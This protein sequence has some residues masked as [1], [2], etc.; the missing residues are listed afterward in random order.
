MQKIQYDRQKLYYKW[1]ILLCILALLGYTLYFFYSRY[2][3]DSDLFRDNVSLYIRLVLVLYFIILLSFIERLPK[4]IFN[5]LGFLIVVPIG[6][7]VSIISFL[8]VGYE[9]ISV[10]GFIF[11]ILSSAVVFDFSTLSF[12]VALFFILLFHFILLSFYPVNQPE[13]L[14]NHIFLLSLAGSIG[15]ATNYMINII[16]NNESKVLQERELLLKEVHHRVKNNL[17]IISS[18]LN[19]QSHS[20]TDEPVKAVIK[21]SQGRVKSIAMIHQLLYQS[22]MYS[23]IDFSKYLEQLMIS[24]RTTY[25]KSG[26]K[27]EY[28]IKAEKIRLDIDTAIK[29]GIITNELVTNSYKY[30]FGKN[31]EGMIHIGL[32]KNENHE[33]VYSIWDNGKGLPKNFNLD[34]TET[35]GLKL[36]KLLSQELKAKLN[37]TIKNGTRFQFVFSIEN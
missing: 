21:E 12:A 25:H 8:T 6:W 11:I 30:A 27:I 36:V 9:G 24:I 1:A 31:Q 15:L 35:L 3:N 23:S 20:V 33:I 22:G 7:T 5:L 28:A 18:L 37:Y 34:Q 17:Q 13:G 14:I 29:L 10:T 16:K 4:K 32:D 2:I 26:T 19:L